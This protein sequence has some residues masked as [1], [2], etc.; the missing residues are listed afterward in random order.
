MWLIWYV[1]ELCVCVCGG[2]SKEH[3][4]FEAEIFCN[5]IYVFTITFD[6][7]NVSLLIKSIIYSKKAQNFFCI[8]KWVCI[9]KYF[10]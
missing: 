10:K 4:L 9:Y 6:Q 8:F 5:M 2:P 1:A 3:N 7:V